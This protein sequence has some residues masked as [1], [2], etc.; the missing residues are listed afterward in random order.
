MNVVRFRSRA[1][2][3]FVDLPRLMHQDVFDLACGHIDNGRKRYGSL[4][5]VQAD[6]SQLEDSGFDF[7]KGRIGDRS[8][9]GRVIGS[10][11]EG[12]WFRRRAH[13]AQEHEHEQATAPCHAQPGARSPAK[14]S[15]LGSGKIENVILHRF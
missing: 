4:S 8:G 14:P 12:P 15:C 9:Q 10:G 2:N 7:A 6:G 11:V 1:E 5:F 13:G 3:T